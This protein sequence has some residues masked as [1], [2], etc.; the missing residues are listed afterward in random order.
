M[1]LTG[2]QLGEALSHWLSSFALFPIPSLL[3]TVIGFLI[4]IILHELFASDHAFGGGKNTGY[5]DS[6]QKNSAWII[7]DW[8]ILNIWKFVNLIAIVK[9]K[10]GIPLPKK[11]SLS[12][13]T[14]E[15]EY[16][17]PP[18]LKIDDQDFPGGPV[19]K[20]PCFH[21][22]VWSMVK[23]LGSHMPHSIAKKKDSLLYNYTCII[24]KKCF[25]YL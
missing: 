8:S 23:E 10:E 21:S 3:L 22:R 1:D 12:F 13:A 11:P 17:E 2:G 5:M 6:S 15:S 18:S 14:I 19:F 7:I 4:K 20:I 24:M 25:L 9:R 16:Y